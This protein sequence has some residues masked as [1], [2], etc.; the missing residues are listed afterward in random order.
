MEPR[1]TIN[2]PWWRQLADA[3]ENQ[4]SGEK[5]E[6]WRAGGGKAPPPTSPPPPSPPPLPILRPPSPRLRSILLPPIHRVPILV[7]PSPRPRPPTLPRWPVLRPLVH[8]VP[9]Q[10]APILR[11][12]PVEILSE[13]FLLV[14]QLPSDKRWNWRVLMLVCRVWHAI[15][16]STPGLHSQLRIRRATQKEVVQTFIQERKTHLGV[17]VDMDDEGDGSDFNAGNFHASF[18]AAIQAAS[19]WSS[20]N[21][22]SP[23]PHGEYKDLEIL[24]PFTHLESIKFACGSGE[25]FEQLVIAISKNTAPNLT[26]MG[27]TDPAAVLCLTQPAVA[28]IYHSLTTLNI[29]LVKPMETPVDILPHLHRLETLEACRLCLPIYPPESSLP[30]INTLRFLYLKSVSV[31]WMAGHVF[32]ALEKCRIIF[33]YNADAILCGKKYRV[34][35]QSGATESV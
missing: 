7:S 19:R 26:V 8:R 15:I 16:L 6:E 33:P 22:I 23:P 31:Q 25:F 5:S 14:S 28:H 32:P 12:I 27:L 11:L 30:L 18:M 24:Q 3:I 4:W 35:D 13:I 1:E 17:I 10:Q 2:H 9:L 21:F 29:Q 34:T 20:L